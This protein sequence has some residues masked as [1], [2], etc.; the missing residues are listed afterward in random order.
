MSEEKAL[1]IL[2]D[3]YLYCRKCK[4]QNQRK[5]YLEDAGKHFLRIAETAKFLAREGE[6]KAGIQTL[7]SDF[8]SQ[9]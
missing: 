4:K 9:L 7:D 1:E 6:N 5:I 3:F 2:C 8:L